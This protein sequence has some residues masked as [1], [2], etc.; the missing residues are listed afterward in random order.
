[1]YGKR[2]HLEKTV[3]KTGENVRDNGV[4]SRRHTCATITVVSIRRRHTTSTSLVPVALTH[5]HENWPRLQSNVARPELNSHSSP[6]RRLDRRRSL[7]LRSGVCGP[8][9]PYETHPCLIITTSRSTKSGMPR[10]TSG[11][12]HKL[13]L[14]HSIYAGKPEPISYVRAVAL[15][16]LNSSSSWIF[17]TP[18]KYQNGF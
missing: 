8:K 12:L 13:K 6:Q 17:P 1:M 15:F 9:K 7:H 11:D 2:F 14:C 4:V 10:H 3:R 18:P 16:V 5:T